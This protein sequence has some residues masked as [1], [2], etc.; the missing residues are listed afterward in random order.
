MKDE[1]AALLPRL[2]GGEAPVRVRLS[3]AKGWR[4]PPNTV[5]VARPGKWG[6]PFRIGELKWF[7]NDA[8]PNDRVLVLPRDNAEAVEA[9]RWLASQ[10]KYRAMV[11][12]ELHGFNLAC[13]CGLDE[14]CHADVLLE[15]AN[16]AIVKA[17]IGEVG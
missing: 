2:E 16:P 1:L 3:R 4:M 13:W 15:L 12:E 14:P 8:D 10:P 6:N 11:C 17:K 5:S 7:I 9:F